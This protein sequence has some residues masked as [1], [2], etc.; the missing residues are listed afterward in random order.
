MKQKIISKV[1][2]LVILVIIL[3]TII[4]SIIQVQ[5]IDS[6]TLSRFTEL[7]V[8]NTV[9]VI[10]PSNSPDKPLN[11][12]AAAV[13]DWLA[14]AYLSSKL[15]L[16]SEGMDINTEFVDQV[17]GVPIGDPGIG[18]ISFGG[19]YVNIPIYHYEV[20]KIAPVIHRGVPGAQ[21]SGEPWAQWYLANGTALTKTAI[22][23]N[24][25]LDLFLVEI[26]KDVEGR[27][28]FISYG[29]GWRGTYAAGKYFEEIIYPN[30][31]SFHMSWII[32]KWEDTNG[33]NFVDNPLGGD[34]YTVIACEPPSVFKPLIG[35][36]V[37]IGV[38][39]STT[40][41][42][43]TLI[44]LYEEIIEPDL[45]EYCEKLGY[46]VTFEFSIEDAQGYS[47]IHQEKVQNF[48]SMD[49]DLIIG[50]RWSSQ[51]QA[52]LSYV[53]EH[54]MLLFSPSSMSSTLSI[55]NDN[56]FRLSPTD[57]VQ[58]PAI[59]EMLWSWGI[60]AVIV[61]Q[62][63]DSWADGIYG[64]F[65]TEYTARGG[66]ILE[67][68]RY[69]SE[70]TEFSSY[71][72]T[73]EDVAES[74][75]G[76]YGVEHI[77]VLI[78]SFHESATIVTQAKDYP[79]MYNLCWF[80]SE[81]TAK[82]QQHLDDAPEESAHLKIFSTLAAPV[83]SS[84]FNEMSDRYNNLVS[85]SLGFYA[86]CDIDIAWII[87]QAVLETQSLD[88][89]DIINIIPDIASR[90]FGY[91]G[92]CLLNENGDRYSCNY[93]IWGYGYVDNTPR[94]IKYGFYDSTTRQVFWDT[95]ALGFT[96]PGH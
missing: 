26:F 27:Y 19:P 63:G 3:P 90:Y 52:S 92:W 33:N 74:K 54:N 8:L 21:G 49:V 14:S 77:G 6:I 22:G 73:A 85:Q 89:M 29:L 91:T 65:E 71:L 50:G 81:G 93:D 18:V 31:D 58:V 86:A 4:P 53:N 57:E 66:V 56:L 35:Q 25:T 47:T 83:N 45:N 10:Y 78:I 38:I 64:N 16:Y 20:N 88:A 94:H 51:A 79:T 72:A 59:V 34:S 75:I 41:G 1:S 37:K 82:S 36:T 84:K 69:A 2:M 39:S 12:G 43:D 24:D 17:T 87:I 5:A 15:S 60:E 95:D 46:G 7:F 62:R 68:I 42:L 96:P 48:H 55:A 28:V 11:R 9:R 76:V 40:S 44:P 70:A 67:R 13:T 23:I 32:V 61:I 80:G 30:L